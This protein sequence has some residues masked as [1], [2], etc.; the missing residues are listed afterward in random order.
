MMVFLLLTGSVWAEKNTK[1]NA[2]L[3]ILPE[4]M[5]SK[6]NK[7][8]VENIES[9]KKSIDDEEPVRRVIEKIAKAWLDS[10][11]YHTIL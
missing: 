10:F 11:S 8:T 1:G 3:C 5:I 4:N 6:L 2:C 9:V 7:K